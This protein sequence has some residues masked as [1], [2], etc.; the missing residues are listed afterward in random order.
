MNKEEMLKM[1]GDVVADTRS[2][3]KIIGTFTGVMTGIK[4]YCRKQKVMWSMSDT[5]VEADR[6]GL[7]CQNKDAE[8][9]YFTYWMDVEDFNGLG[10]TLG[11]V[12]VVE[13]D[14][15][16]MEEETSKLGNKY[17]RVVGWR[18]VK[19]TKVGEVPLMSNV[20]DEHG[21]VVMENGEAKMADL[22]LGKTPYPKFIAPKTMSPAEA[23][24]A[25][26]KAAGI[27]R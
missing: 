9:Q 16:K 23:M 11:S 18:N 14:V 15:T 20:L 26:M 4:V 10:L 27:I 13:C 17:R 8:R 21:N 22:G 7:C 5:E 3:D 1:F 24:A 12:V 25:A 6:I 2:E 19:V